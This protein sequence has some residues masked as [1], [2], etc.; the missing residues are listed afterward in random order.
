MMKRL[1]LAFALLLAA[2]LLNRIPA[3]MAWG[4]FDMYGTAIDNTGLGAAGAYQ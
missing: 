1:L 4:P 3:G 2:P